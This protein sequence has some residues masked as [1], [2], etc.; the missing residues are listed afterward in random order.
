MRAIRKGLLLVVVLACTVPVYADKHSDAKAEVEFGISVAQKGLW[1]EAIF[2]WQKAVEID[3]EYAQ[4]WNDLAIAYEQMGKFDE[5]RKAYET[6]MRLEPNNNFIHENYTSF[7]DV[8]D[9]QNRRSR[10]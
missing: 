3:P 8:Y 7:R 4:A 10:K 1:K 6:A 9:R 5:A 2:R